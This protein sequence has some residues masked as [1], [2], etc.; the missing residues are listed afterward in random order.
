MLGRNFSSF[1]WMMCCLRLGLV[2]FLLV[3][4]LPLAVIHRFGDGRLRGGSNQD[5]VEA[6]VLRLADSG[7]GRHDFDRAVWEYSA[8]FA[9]ADCFVYVFSDSGAARGEISRWKHRLEAGGAF[10]HDVMVPDFLIVE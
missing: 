3:F 8:H 4:V 2:L 1:T 6:H 7:G 5:Q 9:G 10:S